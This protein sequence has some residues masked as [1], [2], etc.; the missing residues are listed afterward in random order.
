MFSEVASDMA[1][2]EQVN[3]TIPAS[4]WSATLSHLEENDRNRTPY[5]RIFV[6]RAVREWI[7]EDALLDTE[8]RLQ[9]LEEMCPHSLPRFSQ[10]EYSIPMGDDVD[11]VRV[12]T[13]IDA[14]L[15]NRLKQV[16][17]ENTDYGDRY[18]SRRYAAAFTVALRLR[19]NGG[20]RQRINDRIE[21]LMDAY[22]TAEAAG[23]AENYDPEEARPSLQ[24]RRSRPA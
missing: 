15:K 5:V 6:E 16:V 18:G 10:T 8:D 11:T 20:R 21:R 12:R 23:E 22:E 3:W 4:E 17:D 2:K 19:R 1:E 24:R 9:E 14:D 7:D 13:W